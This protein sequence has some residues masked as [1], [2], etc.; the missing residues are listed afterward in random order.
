MPE[1]HEQGRALV[2]TFGQGIVKS[3]KGYSL[4]NKQTCDLARAHTT[5]AAMMHLASR[6]DMSYHQHCALRRSVFWDGLRPAARSRLRAPAVHVRHA[7][8]R[9]G[10][11]S[12]CRQHGTL[13]A[14]A[15]IRHST[16]A[17]TPRAAAREDADSA[18]QAFLES[19]RDIPPS[20]ACR[21]SVNP[22]P[23]T[24][25]RRTL[26]HERACVPGACKLSIRK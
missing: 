2:S 9:P 4:V 13:S 18:G 10:F 7:V 16:L 26:L 23:T 14:P 24:A 20:Q 15:G 25:H 3:S 12:T 1:L 21:R 17:Q 5:T 6:L 22:R 19:L 8:G 11:N